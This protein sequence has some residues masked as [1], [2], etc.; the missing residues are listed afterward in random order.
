MTHCRGYRAAAVARAAEVRTLGIDAGPH[1]ALPD[2]VLAAVALPDEAA[3]LAELSAA[4]GSARWD[5]LLFCCKEAVYKAWFPLTGRWL[6]FAGASVTIDPVG[7]TFSARLLVPAP[8]PVFT[9]RWLVRHGL[10]LAAIAV[11]ANPE[12]AWA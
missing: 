5:R 6:G 11:P 1:A 7:H 2:G 8:V 12:S 10:V 9:G 4:D 3:R